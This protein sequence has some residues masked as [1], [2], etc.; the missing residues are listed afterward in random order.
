MAQ[1]IQRIATKAVIVNSE[2]KVLIVREASTYG[3]GTNH[4]RYHLPG[5]RL[6]PGE[7]FLMGL[8]REVREEVG[9]IVTIGPPVFV[10]E[11]SP[12]IKG[13]PHQIVGIFFRC[14]P[15][16][17]QQ[18]ALSEEHDDFAWVKLADLDA[19]DIMTP[20]PDAIRAAFAI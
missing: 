12:V 9:L 6:D 3:D 15:K 7:P 17:A 20:D 18:I 4:G 1:I 2:N 11:W 19:F 10:G 13:Q 16:D 14:I 8:A 5:G